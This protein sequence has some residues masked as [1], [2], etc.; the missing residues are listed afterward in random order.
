MEVAALPISDVGVIYA[1]ALSTATAVAAGIAAWRG[2]KLDVQFSYGWHWEQD[3]HALT[4][5]VHNDSPSR[6]I[7]VLEI[8]WRT[9]GDIGDSWTVPVESI[10]VQAGATYGHEFALPEVL[11]PVVGWTLLGDREQHEGKP[12]DVRANRDAA[13]TLRLPTASRSDV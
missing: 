4:V 13:V 10:S 9:E 6:T 5:Y 1:S 11:A 2:R 12:F 7:H 3:A 8:G